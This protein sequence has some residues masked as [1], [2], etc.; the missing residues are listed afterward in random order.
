[1]PI[2]NS[3]GKSAV[4]ATRKNAL[5][6]YLD[7][8][9]ENGIGGS[10][11]LI[12]PID[13]SGTWTGTAS[14]WTIDWAPDP[15]QDDKGN[16]YIAMTDWGLTFP[17]ATIYDS[18]TGVMTSSAYDNAANYYRYGVRLQS[19]NDDGSV[20]FASDKQPVNNSTHIYLTLIVISSSNKAG[21]GDSL[22]YSVSGKT[23]HVI[24]GKSDVG[25]GNVDNTADSVKN[26]AT[27]ASAT[28]AT[29]LSVY[30]SAIGTDGRLETLKATISIDNQSIN[31][32]ILQFESNSA[33]SYPMQI[34]LGEY[35]DEIRG[36]TI[37]MWIR[38]YVNGAWDDWV[39]VG[40]GGGGSGNV[41]VDLT[42]AGTM[43]FDY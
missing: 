16:Y 3:W 19:I 10:G 32:H 41:D 4:D 8:L 1:M 42:G 35:V 5:P 39:A 40:S 13:L 12:Y 33:V 29:A 30:T 15:A 26:V 36:P 6:P 43:V 23:G 38:E 25:L 20:T 17:G 24:L 11:I 18:E 28:T 22:V 37:G 31:A 27:A 34:A 9:F 21:G 2:E 7:E 14:P